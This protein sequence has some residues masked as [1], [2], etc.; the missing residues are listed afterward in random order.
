MSDVD[1]SAGATSA[2]DE[3]DSIGI[4]APEGA[5]GLPSGWRAVLSDQLLEPYWPKLMAFVGAARSDPEHAV[6]PPAHQTFAA[7]A[8]SDFGDTHASS[9]WVRILTTVLAKRTVWLSRS[10]TTLPANRP[11][12]ATSARSSRTTWTS[13]SQVAT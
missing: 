1:E 5:V 9:S 4:E 11:P 3:Q 13:S 12:Y 7:F 6:Y 8:L 10:P 2:P